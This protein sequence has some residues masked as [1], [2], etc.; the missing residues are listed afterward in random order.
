MPET[1]WTFRAPGCVEKGDCLTAP[2]LAPRGSV[3]SRTELPARSAPRAAQGRAAASRAPEPSPLGPGRCAAA[4]RERSPPSAR[5]S[6]G[7]GSRRPGCVGSVGWLRA[8]ATAG[9][10]AAAPAPFFHAPRVKFGG[11]PALWGGWGGGS[12]SSPPAR[13]TPT[14]R[15]RAVPRGFV[16]GPSRAAGP[17]PGAHAGLAWGP[18]EPRAGAGRPLLAAPAETGRRGGRRADGPPDGA[19]CRLFLSFPL[20]SAPLNPPREARGRRGGG[21]KRAEL[22][23]GR[24]PSRGSPAPAS[25][26]PPGGR[27]NA[28]AMPRGNGTGRAGARRWASSS[29][30]GRRSLELVSGLQAPPNPPASPVPPPRPVGGIRGFPS[31]GGEREQRG[32]GRR[33]LPF[34]FAF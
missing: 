8:G 1:V 26:N 30:P 2:C 5:R 31:V 11:A 29:T 3:C 18:A 23:P 25:P 22:E 28:E 7:S 17:G 12:L 16:L 13:G 33:A 21:E 27:G 4:P 15:G 9:L 32:S 19:V 14:S 34:L 20:L 24:D 6:R 10:P